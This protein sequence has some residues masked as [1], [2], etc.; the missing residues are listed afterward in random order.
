[1]TEWFVY[2][3]CDVTGICS[4]VKRIL[5]A[6]NDVQTETMPHRLCRENVSVFFFFK[7]SV[8]F[9]EIGGYRAGTETI[10]SR[11]VGHYTRWF[12]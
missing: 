3:W 6:T 5:T 7:I 12:T 10:A 11:E 9:P 2:A 1:M 8:F 4:G